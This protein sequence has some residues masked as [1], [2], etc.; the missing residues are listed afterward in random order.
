MKL[1]IEIKKNICII[2]PKKQFIKIYCFGFENF[3]L[4]SE[5]KCWFF[6]FWLSFQ[7]YDEI[8]NSNIDV[9][10]V[11]KINFPEIFPIQQI[12]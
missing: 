6:Q 11:I 3:D 10:L 12:S 1:N 9:L 5:F 8:G 7:K 2:K 4:L